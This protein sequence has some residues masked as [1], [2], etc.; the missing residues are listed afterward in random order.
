MKND[1][2]CAKKYHEDFQSMRRS[3][4]FF[5]DLEEGSAVSRIVLNFEEFEHVVENLRKEIE[6]AH[7]LKAK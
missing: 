7:K 2:T 6:H 5:D 1:K 4:Q 3:F